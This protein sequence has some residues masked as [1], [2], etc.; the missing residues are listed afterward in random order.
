MTRLAFDVE[1][2][3][4]LDNCTHIHCIVTKDLD[5]GKVKT[6]VDGEIGLA[7]ED[8]ENASEI[9]AHNGIKYDI[10]VLQKLWGLRPPVVRD[11]LVTL[12]LMHPDTYT[13]DEPLVK[14]QKLPQ[15]LMGSHSLA[16]WGHRIGEH[17][18]DY[19]GGFE[20]FSQEMLDYCVQDVEVLYKLVK[21]IE[22]KDYSQQAVE[23][24]HKFAELIWLQEQNGFG[25]NLDKARSLHTDLMAR[26]SEL[27]D[28]LQAAF[29]PRIQEMKS[30]YWVAT[31]YEDDPECLF[32]TL[33]DAE[34]CGWG[35]GELE[36]GP[37]KTKSIPFNP[38]SRQ[39]CGDRLRQKYKW[40]VPEKLS[41]DVFAGLKYPEAQLIAEYLMVKKRLG[42]L[43]DGKA[44]WLKLEKNGAIHGAVNT[45]GAVTG[46]CTH[47]R[48]NMAQV[49]KASDRVPFGS[50]CRELFQPTRR[51]WKLV[52]CDASGL[53]LRCLAHYMAR[54]DDGAYAKEVLEGDVH[55]TN[56]KAAGLETRDQAKTFIYAFV[57]G[58]GD[59]KLG[60]IKGKGPKVG[61]QL[62]SKFLE[63]LPALDKLIKAVKAKVAKTN[64][65]LGLDGR[66]LHVRSAHSALNT[67]LQ[68]A[69][70]V[71]MKQAL[72]HFCEE[73]DERE[74]LYGL[75]ANVH[76]EFQ[77]EVPD[78]SAYEAA[79]I[80][81]YSIQKAGET[82]DFRCP[83]AGEAK[84]GNN[85]AETH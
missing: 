61:K 7:I 42:Q 14:K 20:T 44:A 25:I 19:K 23:L 17:K 68:S 62:R 11:T 51:G 26:H 22:A 40:K 60:D 2:N 67:L 3:D 31:G 12:R 75:C 8:L 54:W 43:S 16:A 35:R 66:I 83:L 79:A 28:E 9:W 69:G 74:I 76:D 80:A 85:W 59:G 10:P 4:L 58:A 57:Y 36:Q 6:F 84:V 24:E 50:R 63:D 29:P 73:M 55:T 1:G 48:P 53:E 30:R 5:T 82:L 72:I 49:P 47:S 37:H 81:E 41:D 38:G 64:T 45:N 32:D 21:K 77:V 39:E 65:L 34:E 15:N 56:Q 71:I 18:Q 27:E 70:A 33:A 46:R 78:H 13:L 52:G